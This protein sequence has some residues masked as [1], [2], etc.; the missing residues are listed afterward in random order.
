MTQNAYF[1]HRNHVAIQ[2]SIVQI[3]DWIHYRGLSNFVELQHKSEYNG[4]FWRDNK[5]NLFNIAKVK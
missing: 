3:K 5:S 2:M 4:V 1:V